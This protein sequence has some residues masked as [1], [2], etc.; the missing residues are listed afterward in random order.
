M[1]QTTR[2]FIGFGLCR[3]AGAMSS[4]LLKHLLQLSSLP[5]EVFSL[6]LTIAS[7]LPY[8]SPQFQPLLPRIFFFGNDIFIGLLR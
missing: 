3:L 7:M 2:N 5:I 6:D 8:C 1:N 4:N